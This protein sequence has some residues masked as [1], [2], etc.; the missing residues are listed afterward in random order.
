MPALPEKIR[1]GLVELRTNHGLLYVNPSLWERLYLLWTFRNF[2]RLPEQVLN[3]RQQRLIEK[4]R[5]TS[6][7]ARSGPLAR[8]ALI[9]A[10]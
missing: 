1:S 2:H 6:V 9:G 4:L 10:I 8:T 7:V 5:R 3:P